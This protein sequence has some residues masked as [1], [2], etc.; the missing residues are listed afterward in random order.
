VDELL[1]EK[2]QLEAIREWW[3]DN[4][5]YLVGGAALGVLAL[6]G[7]NQYSA[8]RDAQR[9]AAGALYVELRTAA[10]DDADDEARSILSE[11]REDYPG[12]A[13][14]DQAG[15]M[16][17]VLRLD[18]GQVRGAAEE[19]RYVM[20]STSD[21]ELGLIA[22]LRL[23]RVLADQQ[24]YAEAMTTLDVDSGS[25]SA[26][27]DEVRGDIHVALGDTESARTAYNAALSGTETNTVDRNLVQMKLDDLPGGAGPTATAISPDT[28]E[29][30]QTE[31]APP[32]EG[33]GG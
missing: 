5:W 9:E 1:S 14:T 28:D 22:R 16:V 20:E 31:A 7:W 15:L 23:A 19:L 4:G 12:S 24:D 2:E 21:V 17:A 27:Y 25:F 32:A 8:Y 13:Y 18:S 30:P 26:R 11:M 3:R 33:E 10:S 6:V 29:Q